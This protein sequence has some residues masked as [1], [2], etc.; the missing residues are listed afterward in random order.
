MKV[1]SKKSIDLKWL[2]DPEINKSRTGKIFSL[3]NIL[4]KGQMHEI[5]PNTKLGQF[6]GGFMRDDGDPE[7]PQGL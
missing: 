5:K 1:K 7:E 4:P 6:K 3:E 2:L